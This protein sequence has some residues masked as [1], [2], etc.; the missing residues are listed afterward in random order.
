MALDLTPEEERRTAVFYAAGAFASAC[1][2]AEEHTPLAAPTSLVHHVNDL[3]SELWGQ[4]FS[5]AEIR[6]AFEDAVRDMPR[7][8]V[9]ERNGTGIRGTK[10]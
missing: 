3:M 1:R 4:G 5:Q 9:E 7:F 10:L 8:A 6:E 2:T